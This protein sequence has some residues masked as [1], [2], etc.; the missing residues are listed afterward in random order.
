MAAS[1]PPD[2]STINPRLVPRWS[3]PSN[4]SRP[5]W[6][7]YWKSMMGVLSERKWREEEEEWERETDGRRWRETEEEQLQY[8]AKKL[9]LGFVNSPQRKRE[10]CHSS[11]RFT[12]PLYRTAC[13]ISAKSIIHFALAQ[14]RF[15]W[16]GPCST[17]K[18]DRMLLMP[19]R[20]VMSL[21]SFSLTYPP[22]PE[23]AR[24]RDHT[25]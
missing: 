9:S 16:K 20:Q 18:R 5:K 19:A 11:W 1:Q 14:D 21:L 22:R 23:E 6:R 25:T 13:S 12:V 8:W 7:H 4:A 17:A 15:Y 10:N 3:N 24:M 2:R